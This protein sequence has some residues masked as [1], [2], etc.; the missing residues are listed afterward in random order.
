MP[1]VNMLGM[2]CCTVDFILRKAVLLSIVTDDC[3][4]SDW[5]INRNLSRG[6]GVMVPK[7]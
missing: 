3:V 6:I 4:S 2:I 1:K 5:T 7:Q